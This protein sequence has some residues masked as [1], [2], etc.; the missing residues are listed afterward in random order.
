LYVVD[1]LAAD[2]ASAGVA[3]LIEAPNATVALRHV[4]QK[5]FAVKPAK[6]QDVAALMGQGVKVE[7][8]AE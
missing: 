5:R 8:A 1:E 6:P 2:G 4:W 3:K 7:R